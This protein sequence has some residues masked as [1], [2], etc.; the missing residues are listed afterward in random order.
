MCLQV[1]CGKPEEVLPKVWKDWGVTRLCFE[2][3][4]EPYAKSRDQK[5]TELAEEAGKLA[6]VDMQGF[7]CISSTSE[8]IARQRFCYTAHAGIEVSTHVS[9]TLYD[10]DELIELNGGSPP[11]SMTQFQKLAEKA[12][13]PQEPAADPSD[14]FPPLPASAD[15]NTIPSLKELGYTDKPTTQFPVCLHPYDTVFKSV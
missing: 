5:I 6:P 11:S 9:H 14:G 13:E 15:A 1:L 12:G 8:G 7:Q 2:S 3:D 4:T 10:P